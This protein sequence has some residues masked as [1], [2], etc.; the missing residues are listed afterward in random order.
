MS[1]LKILSRYR[2]VIHLLCSAGDQWIGP[3]N[4]LHPC[5]RG[6]IVELDDTRIVNDSLIMQC[7]VLY[8]DQYAVEYLKLKKL[9]RL[10]L[11]GIQ[12]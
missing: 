1:A 5:E 4:G 9:V 11:P 6:L 7:T 10:A 12:V 3:S 8:H 2:L